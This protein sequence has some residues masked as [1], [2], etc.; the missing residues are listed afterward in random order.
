MEIVQ[1]QCV[2]VVMDFVTQIINK[3]LP[4]PLFV[5]LLHGLSTRAAMVHSVILSYILQ[6]L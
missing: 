4:A 3:S 2:L 1:L 5:I 6:R